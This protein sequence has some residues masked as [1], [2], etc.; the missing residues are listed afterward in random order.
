MT[1]TESDAK[2]DGLIK[3]EVG[4]EMAKVAK[5][6]NPQMFQYFKR[7]CEEVGREPSDVF[8]EMAVRSLNNEG[9][10][11]QVLDSEINMSQ[12][13]AD[14]IRMEDVKYVKELTEELGLGQEEES[15]DPIDQLINKRLEMV[16]SSPLENLRTTGQNPEGVNGQVIEHM[17]SLQREIDR[18]ESKIDGSSVQENEPRETQTREK[19]SVDELWD[20]SDGEQEEPTQKPDDVVEMGDEGEQEEEDV[21]GDGPIDGDATEAVTDSGTVQ[22]EDWEVDD[23]DGVED[24]EW[25]VEQDEVDRIFEEEVVDDGESIIPTSKDGET[26]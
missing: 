1:F 23:E 5:T 2:N 24:D 8:G 20:D 10:A 7:V 16:T 3:R 13:K 25:D 9:Y 6:Q 11:Q 22:E 26:E 12:I 19:K 17:E 18:L 21:A 14:E 15:Q 4:K